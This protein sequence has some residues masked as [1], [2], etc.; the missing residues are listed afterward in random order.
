MTQ[1]GKI[2]LSQMLRKRIN[3]CSKWFQVENIL[4][5]NKLKMIERKNVKKQKKTNKNLRKIKQ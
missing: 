4:I 3:T 2:F 1:Y 5:R